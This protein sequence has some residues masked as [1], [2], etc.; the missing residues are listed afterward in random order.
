MRRSLTSV[1]ISTPNP[2]DRI[3]HLVNSHQLLYILSLGRDDMW[4]T[5][6][7]CHMT[8]WPVL[9]TFVPFYSDLT[10]LSQ[11]LCVSGRVF[12]RVWALKR[13]FSLHSFW[14]RGSPRRYSSRSCWAGVSAVVNVVIVN[15][16]K[17]GEE[18]RDVGWS[19]TLRWH[20]RGHLTKVPSVQTLGSRSGGAKYVC[21]WQ[22]VS[23]VSK[24]KKGNMIAAYIIDQPL[25]EEKT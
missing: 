16:K 18:E 13:R 8:K 21:V 1:G 7:P 5:M 2:D 14:G 25:K 3:S 20:F 24:K 17:K 12:L 10:L 23:S 6:W 15:G 9:E 11:P 4:P 22:C 19:V